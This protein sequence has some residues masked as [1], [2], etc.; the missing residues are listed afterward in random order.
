[1]QTPAEI[2]S[3]DWKTELKFGLRTAQDLVNAALIPAAQIDDYEAL[4]GKYQFFLPRYYAS[5]IDR[6]D[7]HCPIRKQA[8]PDLLELKSSPGFVPDPLNDLRY[9]PQ[10]R[11]THRYRHRALLHL[12][13]ACSMYCRFC[14]RKTLLNELSA[15]LFGG[16]LADALAYLRSHSEIEEVILS[17]GDPLML[18]DEALSQI[19]QELAAIPHLQRIRFHTRV[20]VTF[21]MRITSELIERLKNARLPL[22]MVTHFNHPKEIT[23]LA[24]Q[25]CNQFREANIPLLNQSVLLAG[26]NASVKVLAGL[27]RALFSSGVFPYYLHHPDPAEGTAYFDLPF[28]TGL[29]LHRELRRQLPGYLV[30]RYVVDIVGEP[31]KQDV[32]LV[33]RE[34]E[35]LRASSAGEASH[36]QS[37]SP[38]GRLVPSIIS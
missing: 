27:S 28:S 32:E 29:E 3:T 6:S 21:P 30:P 13:S 31:F 23:T 14:F 7:P 35:Q 22:V 26:V 9:Q 18:G 20:P 4:L 24:E 15:E 2:V 38:G 25:A 11:I 37:R 19:L 34:E 17:G 12:T 36:P 10:N 5:L 1:M 8:I 33:W 16:A